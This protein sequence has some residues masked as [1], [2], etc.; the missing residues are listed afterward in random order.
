MPTAPIVTSRFAEYMENDNRTH[1]MKLR[2]SF[3]PYPVGWVSRETL[4]SYIE[5]NDPVTGK[6][7]IEEIIYALTAPLTEEEKNFKPERRPRRERLLEPDTEENLQRLFLE[8]GWTDGLPIVLPTEE[9][10]AEMLTGT[11]RDPQEVV[12]LMSVTP[13][14]ERL[15]Y[16]VEKVAVN[17]VMA[18]ARPEHL[19]VILAIAASNI[20]SLP[21]STGSYGC[22]AVVNGPVAKELGMNGGGAAFGPFNYSN[23][24]IGR[25]WTLMSINFGNARAG[26]TYM[27]THGNGLSFTNMCCCENEEKSPWEPFHVQKGFKPGESTVSLFRGWNVHNLNIGNTAAEILNSLKNFGMM[28]NFTA[29]LD[30]LVAKGLAKEGFDSADKFREWLVKE[31]DLPFL[32]KEKVNLIVVG[33]ESNPIYITSDFIYTA[34]MPVDEW[35][36][37]GGIK[38]DARPLR[39]PVAIT[40]ADGSCGIA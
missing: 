21:S 5:G 11:D 8:N 30:P 3:P 22:M 27:A 20:T 1:G 14:E 10:V 15:E 37:K 25:A 33:G 4:R 12:G 34:T 31:S 26:Q 6:P 23:A 19:P 16:T 2:W 29:I 18:G 39:M 35:I 32:Q 9:R 36:P 7:L 13:T 17:A 28:G 38:K 24:V 40:C